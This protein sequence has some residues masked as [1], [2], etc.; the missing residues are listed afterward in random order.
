[1]GLGQHHAVQYS[2]TAFLNADK[3]CPAECLLRK[4]EFR[5]KCPQI[6]T[7]INHACKGGVVSYAKMRDKNK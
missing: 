7:G 3:D 5:R 2:I 1:M 6:K 4:N